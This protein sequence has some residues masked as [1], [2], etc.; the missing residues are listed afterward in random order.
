MILDASH[1]SA[2]CHWP[3]SNERSTIC[4]PVSSRRWT[5][6]ATHP[7]TR[8]PGSRGA[9]EQEDNIYGGISWLSTGPI[10]LRQARLPTS[11]TEQWDVVGKRSID[12]R[13][14]DR[15]RTVRRSVV[16]VGKDCRFTRGGRKASPRSE[17]GANASPCTYQT[18]RSVWVRGFAREQIRLRRRPTTTRS[19][20]RNF[21][22][23]TTGFILPAITAVTSLRGRKAPP[24]RLSAQQLIAE[25]VRQVQ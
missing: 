24:C 20:T 16:N 2:P 21:S 1:V 9:W 13:L 4:R 8:S 15:N 7:A 23:P 17:Q 3:C 18:F 6:S 11:G 22:F 19:L 10:S 12:C 25:R 14:R 5:R